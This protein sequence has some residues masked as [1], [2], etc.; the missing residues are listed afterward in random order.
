MRK[1]LLFVFFFCGVGL[2]ISAQ[3]KTV[4][5]TI[6]A[7]EDGTTIVGATVNIKGTTTGVTSDLDGNYSIT[8]SEGDV[9]VFRFVGMKTEE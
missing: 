8:T 5:G 7:A 6:T 2:M 1:L 9:L 4:T 3:E